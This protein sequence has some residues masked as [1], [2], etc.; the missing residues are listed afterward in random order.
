MSLRSTIV[1]I[2]AFENTES[3]VHLAVKISEI[4]QN[5][6]LVICKKSDKENACQIW[7]LYLQYQGR[8]RDKIRFIS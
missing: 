7:N 4:L 2:Y 3:L 8:Y 5:C 6:K 1:E